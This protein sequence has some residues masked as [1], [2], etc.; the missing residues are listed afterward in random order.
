MP[1]RTISVR[2]EEAKVEQVSPA[3]RLGEHRGGHLL[4]FEAQRGLA[5]VGLMEALSSPR[6]PVRR[7]LELALNWPNDA[8]QTQQSPVGT[9]RT[10]RQLR[11]AAIDQLV[12]AYQAGATTHEL[13]VRFGIWRGTVGKHLK[14]RGID[15][16]APIIG[17]EDVQVAANLYRA[18]WTLRQ[19]ARRYRIGDETARSYLVAAGVQMRARGRQ[20]PDSP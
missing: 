18:G 5:M 15:T 12:V 14:E 2:Q 9:Y 8:A 6:R 11:P 16:R 3:V 20:P 7:L 1:E 19:I 17:P 13:A 10:A 4:Q